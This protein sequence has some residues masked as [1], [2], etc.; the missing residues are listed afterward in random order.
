MPGSWPQQDHPF[1]T[2]TSCQV[3]SKTDRRYNCI[4]WAAGDDRNN[5]WPDSRGIGYWPS[6]VPR[7]ESISAF[8]QAYETLGYKLC[9]DGTVEA[10][11]EK[12]AIFGIGPKGQE[13]PTHAA[14]QRE[15]GEWTSKMGTLED[16]DHDV[17]DSVRG[18]VYG[19]V[20]CFMSRPRPAKP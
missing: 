12:I 8:M 2:A 10:G 11:F 6:G 5:W 17:A 19:N 14:L 3:K 18:P 7:V 16:I 4:A 15:S 1:L 9:Y 20:I 13:T